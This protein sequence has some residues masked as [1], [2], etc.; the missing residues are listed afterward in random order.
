MSTVFGF[1][2]PS[3]TINVIHNPIHIQLSL[4]DWQP[5]DTAAAL[6]STSRMVDKDTINGNSLSFAHSIYTKYKLQTLRFEEPK[7]V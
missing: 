2:P 3:V 5:A 7:C 6:P 1:N 4:D